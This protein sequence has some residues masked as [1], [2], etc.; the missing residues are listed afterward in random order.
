MPAVQPTAPVSGPPTPPPATPARPGQRAAQRRKKRAQRRRTRQERCRR[1]EAR[2]RCQIATLASSRTCRRIRVAD[3]AGFFGFSER[4]LYRW[5]HT[6]A[7]PDGWVPLGRTPKQAPNEVRNALFSYLSQHGSR[8]GVPRLRRQ[9]PQV[10][11]REM[12]EFVRRFKAVERHRNG[13]LLHRLTWLKP[14][15]TWTMDFTE[16]AAALEHPYRSILCVRDLGSG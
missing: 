1:K 15:A 2:R 10:G 6:A 5:Q 14:G 8:I 12:E 11:K 16:P 7:D 9:F 3:L 13:K 4:S